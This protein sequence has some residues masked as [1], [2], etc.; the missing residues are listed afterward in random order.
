MDPFDRNL[1][2]FSQKAFFSSSTETKGNSSSFG[3][4]ATSALVSASPV[5][6]DRSL[7]G[8]KGVRRGGRDERAKKRQSCHVL[9]I[10]LVA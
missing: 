4:R 9:V 8:E 5:A 6:R 2:Q 1:G 7:L 10:F 3:L